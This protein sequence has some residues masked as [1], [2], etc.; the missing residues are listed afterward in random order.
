MI[1]RVTITGADDSVDPEALRY[2][3]EKFPFVEWGIL[4]GSR[5]GPRPRFPSNDWIARVARLAKKEGLQLSAHLC[6]SWVKRWV[7]NAE[8]TWRDRK[9][10]DAFQRI[11]FN[12]HGQYHKAAMGFIAT[13][14]QTKDAPQEYIFQHDG[15]ND[16]LIS[17]F[18]GGASIKA[19]VL[20]DVSGGAG[21]LPKSWPAPIG[22]YC[23]YA[24]GLGPDNLKE[25]IEHILAAAGDTRIW[26]DMETRVRS[27]DDARL[28][29]AKVEKCLSIA[30]GFVSA[31]HK[32]TER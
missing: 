1:D 20:H 3:S 18:T 26:I 27:E 8:P 12:F 15:V 10:T 30:E 2:Y 5:S 32:R 9:L 4:F 23:G 21:I 25:Q 31:S 17:T 29:L 24:G 6:G 7:L 19:Y 16:S 11:Q 14:R 22:I 13:L 28:V